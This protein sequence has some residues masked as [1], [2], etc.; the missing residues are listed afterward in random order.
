MVPSFQDAGLILVGPPG[1]Q[2]DEHAFIILGWIGYDH[3]EMRIQAC[4]RQIDKQCIAGIH[5]LA[6]VAL[7]QPFKKAVERFVIAQILQN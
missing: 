3:P 5:A 7:R 2:I 6:P 4:A 1:C